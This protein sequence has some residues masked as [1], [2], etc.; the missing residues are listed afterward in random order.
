MSPGF[1]ARSLSFFN[2]PNGEAVLQGASE[3]RALRAG[4]VSPVDLSALPLCRVGR[5]SPTGPVDH[6]HDHDQD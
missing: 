5:A 6:D 3:G 4:A 2:L 1:Y